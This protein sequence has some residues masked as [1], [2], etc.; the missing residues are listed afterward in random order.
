MMHRVGQKLAAGASGLFRLGK[1]VATLGAIGGAAYLGA[2]EVH[3]RVSEEVAAGKENAAYITEQGAEGAVAGAK[4]GAKA[5]I[6]PFGPPPAQAAKGIDLS[7]M[8]LNQLTA[9][10]MNSRSLSNQSL[11]SRHTTWRGDVDWS[12][13]WAAGPRRGRGDL[14]RRVGGVAR[15]PA[16]GVFGR[17]G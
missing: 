9:R 8:D 11:Q 12:A 15:V 17:V 16:R 1:K 14:P 13:H 3:S 4:A 7:G 10:A 2:K 5:A 6:N